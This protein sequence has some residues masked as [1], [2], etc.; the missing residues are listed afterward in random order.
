MNEVAVAVC[1]LTKNGT[2]IKTNPKL[3]N[4]SLN[5]TMVSRLL[6]AQLSGTQFEQLSPADIDDIICIFCGD[7]FDGMYNAD[8]LKVWPFNY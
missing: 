6:A 2:M 3:T 4:A 1:V 8:P 7:D 5:D